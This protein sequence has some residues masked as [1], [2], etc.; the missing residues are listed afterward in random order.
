VPAR[1]ASLSARSMSPP[2]QNGLIYW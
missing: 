1:N 2:A